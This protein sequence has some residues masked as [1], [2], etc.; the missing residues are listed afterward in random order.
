MKKE[1]YLPAAGKGTGTMFSFNGALGA[2]HRRPLS[3]ASWGL[4]GRGPGGRVRAGLGSP[5][6]PSSKPGRERQFRKKSRET[7]IQS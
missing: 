5:C 1:G 3:R 2:G 7:P 4:Q 6:G